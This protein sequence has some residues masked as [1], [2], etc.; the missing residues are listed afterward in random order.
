MIPLTFHE[1]HLVLL[2]DPDEVPPF[3]RV[4]RG[5]LLDQAVF[6]ALERELAVLVMRYMWRPDVDDMDVL[7]RSD[8]LLILTAPA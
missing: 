8:T 5:G 7:T 2:C 3:R 4:E 1:E 6:P